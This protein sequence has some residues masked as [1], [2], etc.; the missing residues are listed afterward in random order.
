[1]DRSA[2]VF[3]YMDESGANPRNIYQARMIGGAP[4]F[5]APP[6]GIT[7]E[8]YEKNLKD[9]YPKYLGGKG[10]DLYFPRHPLPWFDQDHIFITEG[11]PKAI[12]ACRAGIPCL[13]IQGKDQFLVKNTNLFVPGLERL[14]E[15]SKLSRI[16]YIADSDA[17]DNP[18]IRNSAIKFVGMLNGR[19]GPNFADF[20]ILPALPEYGKTG[21]DDYLNIKGAQDFIKNFVNWINPWE[22]GRYFE[23]VNKLNEEL[24]WV[25]GTTNYIDRKSRKVISSASAERQ[26]APVCSAAGL[27]VNPYAGYTV[28]NGMS[29][30][31]NTFDKNPFKSSAD[32]VDFHPGRGEW[33]EVVADEVVQETVYNLWRE[34]T[35]VLEEGDVSPFLE[36]LEY[37]IPDPIGRDLLLKIVAHRILHAEEKAPLAIF[38]YGGEGTGKTC[39][40]TALSQAITQNKN[41]I[42]IGSLR[43]ENPHE[44][45]HLC[46]QFVCMEEP[47][48]GVSRKDI[49][50][51]LKLYIDADQL[52]CNPKGLQQYKITNRMLFWINTNEHVFPASGSAR[53]WLVL[54]SPDQARADL[55][56]ACWDWMQSTPNFGGMLAYYI[57]QNYGG[58]LTYDIQQA[59]P[60]V[61]AKKLLLVENQDPAIVEYEDFINELPEDLLALGSIPTRLQMMLPPYNEKNASHRQGITRVLG[62]GYPLVAVGYDNKVRI[63]DGVNST[64]RSVIKGVST[65]S[66]QSTLRELYQKWEQHP[67]LR[68]Q[69]RKKFDV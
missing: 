11:I 61:E 63:A 26:V 46:K 67:L 58:A 62:K 10:F 27:L 33:I 23:L 44:D 34:G 1:M 24:V 8:Q 30:L 57:Q 29:N 31:N 54:R 52:T 42:H 49:E 19:R 18:D 6:T 38:T 14:L 5:D 9:A 66:D 41:Y 69:F 51:L 3:P 53:R 59:A 12:R 20:L 56:K 45:N 16:T 25:R 4:S 64:F 37:A 7:R 32:R 22:G 21:L 39:I 17:G 47:P 15:K 65:T 48:S 13:S 36:L 50:N 43:P 55:A 35:P 40:A 60:Q 2:I 68:N 28:R